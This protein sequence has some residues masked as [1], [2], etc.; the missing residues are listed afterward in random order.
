MALT[1]HDTGS[2]ADRL[3]VASEFNGLSL[4]FQFGEAGSPMRN[5]FLT[6]D[7]SSDIRDKYNALEE[8]FPHVECRAHWIAVIDPYLD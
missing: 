7:D 3:R 6:G 4:I 8:A 2:G 5:V 1:I